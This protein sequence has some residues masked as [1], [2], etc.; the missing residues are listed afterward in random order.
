MKIDL[1]LQRYVEWKVNGVMQIKDA[2]GYRVKLIYA[3]GSE[4]VQQKSGFHTE[5][6][7]EAARMETIGQLYSNTYVVYE[8]ISVKAFY[9]FWLEYVMR[10][11]VSND[12]YKGYKSKIK[13]HIIPQIGKKKLSTISRADV[14]KLYNKIFKKSKSVVRVVKTIIGTSMKFALE[15]KMISYNPAEDI[16]L[17]KEKKQKEFRV[18]HI[19]EQKTLNYDQVLV[20][21]NAAKDT[22][23]Y[24]QVMF[25]V[26]MGLRCSEILG[27]KY[28]DIDYVNRTLHVERQLGTVPMSEKEDFAP[29][30]YTKQEIKVKTESSDRELPIPDMLFDAILKERERYEKNK[31]RRINDK[32]YPF[33]DE[34][35]ICCSSYGR[36]RSRCYHWPYF[37]KLLKD[38]NLPNVRWHDLR[39]TYCTILLKN[40]FNAKAV[41]KLMGHAKEIITIDVYGDK[42]ELIGDC[43]DVLEP[44]IAEV[45]SEE[46]DNNIC[47]LVDIDEFIED[48]FDEKE[49]EMNMVS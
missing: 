7:A 23:I 31:S 35:Y 5:K 36:P 38:N 47:E 32:H 34:N 20:L 3:D 14:Q 6:E 33:F 24:L 17:P 22:K 44:Y 19:D 46:S 8:K 25:A 45:I 12:T 11:N 43:L 41:S 9:E 13:N 21:V 49:I 2:Y 27:L 28:T 18:R 1:N 30:T 10:P 15:N 39:S 37:K 26:L 42:K 48:L 29:K 16:D 4:L 40:D